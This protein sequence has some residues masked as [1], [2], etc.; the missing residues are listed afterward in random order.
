MVVGGGIGGLAAAHRLA[1]AG[2]EV[3]LLERAGRVG[4][5]LRTERVDGWVIERGPDAI[6]TSKPAAVELARRVGIE[7]AIIGTQAHHRGA[8]VVCR[9]RL[10]RIPEGFSVV[11]PAR[12]APLLASPILSARGKARAAIERVV[13][14]GRPRDDESL[15]SFV[16]RRF[17]VEL[18]ERL[19][20]PL[21]SGIYG[22]SPRALSLG[23][24]MPRFLALEREHGSVSAGLSRAPGDT[25]ARGA[26]YSMFVGF[27]DGMQTLPDAVARVLGDR[28]RLGVPAIGLDRRQGGRLVVRTPGGD[29]EADGVVLALE[30][31][32]AAS[33]LAP[34]DA[35]AA[36]LLRSVDHGSAATATLGYDR[37]DIPHPLDAFGF[38]VPAVERTG[39]LASTWASVKWPGRAPEG[40]ALL[41][42]FLGG[43]DHPDVCDRTDA[44]L[45]ALARRGLRR[46]MGIAA[47]P[48]L[49]R[50]DRFVRAMPRYHV[51][52]RRRAATVDARLA[53]LPGI[54]L[55]GNAL[56]G[57]GIPDA[58]ASGWRAADRLRG[59]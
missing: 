40:K 47:R 12:L 17:G 52:H 5:L 1:R 49:V 29:L 7:D 2:R 44:E 51:G 15:A 28:V 57:V 55:A 56:H 37:S 11:A 20:Q 36:D 27:R 58:V 16:T 59:E 35:L 54:E 53:R 19:A 30:A 21:A 33:L 18:L 38:V 10:E 14:R 25:A 6:L 42:V 31:F 50:V 26:R 41:R 46:L 45:V 4:G 9:G 13:P 24:T 3:V 8:Y 43:A 32:G 39:L 22:A 48:E 23:A 34:H